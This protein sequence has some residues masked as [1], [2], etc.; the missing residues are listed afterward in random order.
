[1][2]LASRLSALRM[3]CG[4]FCSR[5]NAEG[6]DFSAQQR[7]ENFRRRFSGSDVAQ[8]LRNEFRSEQGMLEQNTGESIGRRPGIVIHQRQATNLPQ[9]L[10]E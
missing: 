7:L 2:R 5:D 6:V 3:S 10:A 1:M 9:H 8:K 4:V